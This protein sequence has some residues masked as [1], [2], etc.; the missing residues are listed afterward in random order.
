MDFQDDAVGRSHTLRALPLKL[1]FVSSLPSQRATSRCCRTAF[2]LNGDVL[3]SQAE[4]TPFAATPQAN[5]SIHLADFDLSPYLGYLPESLPVRLQSAVLRT[6]MCRCRL[7]APVAALKLQGRVQAKEVKVL[8]TAQRAL[9]S[10][11]Y[12]AGGCG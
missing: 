6:P 5:A 8:D 3:E 1:P 7:Q 9:L 2:Q 10:L 11:G 4:A 12:A